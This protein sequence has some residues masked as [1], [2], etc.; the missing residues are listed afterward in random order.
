[1][2]TSA[3]KW[4]TAS[5]WI[6]QQLEKEAIERQVSKETFHMW[7]R[8]LWEGASV[9]G[10]AT[11]WYA[12][13]LCWRVCFGVLFVEVCATLGYV[14]SKSSPGMYSSCQDNIHW[15]Q[16]KLVKFHLLDLRIT[17]ERSQARPN[18]N[19]TTLFLNRTIPTN[20]MTP[21]ILVLTQL[22]WNLAMTGAVGHV[23][24]ACFCSH[25]G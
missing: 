25:A 8:T 15:W 6:E 16:T 23:T 24:C 9:Y 18:H 19:I 20:T 22:L 10:V 5:S 21:W 2:A 14:G 12:S 17:R 13:P 4:K 3:R 7:R 1:M 11:C